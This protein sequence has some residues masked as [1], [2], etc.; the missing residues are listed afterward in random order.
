MNKIIFQLGLLAFCV[1][2]VFFGT[3]EMTLME[4]IARA[5]IVFIAVVCVIAGSLLVS[6]MIVSKEEN[7]SENA[8]AGHP[9]REGAGLRKPTLHSAK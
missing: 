7:V 1:S 3:Q 2:A 6:S 8:A 4:T 9:G 5:F